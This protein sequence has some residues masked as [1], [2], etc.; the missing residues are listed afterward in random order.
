MDMAAY[1]EC[2]RNFAEQKYNQCVQ[3]ALAIL[4][5]D[6]D[7]ELLQI[8]L[9]SLQRLGKL[10]L[11]ERIGRDGLRVSI[12]KPWERS[13]LQL[14]L[15]QVSWP[16]VVFQAA[17]SRQR[18][19]AYY[20]AGER[21]LT[22]GAREPAIQAFLACQTTGADC[23]E[24]ELAQSALRL[25][26]AH[27]T[28][29][30]EDEFEVERVR[31]MHEGISGEVKVLTPKGSLPFFTP[32]SEAHLGKWLNTSASAQ[33]GWVVHEEPEQRL[34]PNFEVIPEEPTLP[35][36]QYE[37]LRVFISSTFRDMHSEREILVKKVFPQ[38]RQFCAERWLDLIEVDLRWGIPEE[39]RDV[40]PICLAELENS[41]Y[42][43]AL[44][45]NRY[46][47]VP[48]ISKDT[49]GKHPWLADYKNRSVTELEIVYRL[50][51]S[52][53]TVRRSFFYFRD[54]QADSRK[55]LTK[56]PEGTDLGI[57]RQENLKERIMESGCPVYKNYTSPDSIG[58]QILNDL[59]EAIGR[60][61]PIN[62]IQDSVLAERIEHEAV[63]TAH[64]RGFVPRQGYTE[65]LNQ[66]LRTS[67]KPIVVVGNAG[68]GKSALLANWTR[69][70][71]KDNPDD[72]V[73]EHY[74]G[75]TTKSA[76][77]AEIVRRWIAELRHRYRFDPRLARYYEVS[78]EVVELGKLL[79][80]FHNHLFLAMRLPQQRLIFV[81]DG[82]D[83]LEDSTDES[84]WWLPEEFSSNIKLLL[85]ARPGPSVACARDR[86]W[87]VEGL[88]EFTL[89]ELSEAAPV[90]LRQYGKEL[91]KQHIERLVAASQ[92]RQPL[93]LRVVLNEL[94]LFG[95]HEELDKCL[96][97]HL[98]ASDLLALYRSVFRRW[99]SDYNQPLYPNLVE[100]AL[101]LLAF[102][103]N[104]LT[105]YEW[106]E[107]LRGRRDALPRIVWAPLFLTLQAHLI[108]KSG[109]WC[110][111]QE[112]LNH[113][114]TRTFVPTEED[115][116][117]VH[118]RLADYFARS[119]PVDRKLSEMPW[120]LQMC[121]D[122][123][124]LKQCLSDLDLTERFWLEGRVD[125]LLSYWNALGSASSMV[126]AY[127]EALKQDEAIGIKPERLAAN[128][129]QLAD[130]F[131]FVGQLE[132]AES[133]YRKALRIGYAD[134]GPDHPSIAGV[135]DRLGQ[136]LVRLGKP[137]QAE[138]LLRKVLHAKEMA[139]GP[140]HISLSATLLALGEA[141]EAQRRWTEAERCY[142][143]ALELCHFLHG[144]LHSNTALCAVKL[145][146]ILFHRGQTDRAE[147]FCK[148][149]II[150]NKQLPHADNP[151]AWRAM[152]VL[153]EIHLRK[154]RYA[155]A[156]AL[157]QGILDRR[158]EIIGLED[159]S[160]AMTLSRLGLV[161]ALQGDLANGTKL[162][163][164]ALDICHRT[165]GSD[166]PVTLEIASVITAL[167]TRSPVD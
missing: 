17:D 85:S 52:P 127:H 30:P 98:E 6:V 73:V 58:Q 122:W 130:I 80:A 9:I 84:L 27:G 153:A 161:K 104:G 45:G 101:S 151:T 97:R 125:E 156:E 77:W 167:P 114:V 149:A 16:D 8:V 81:L 23:L 1:Q 166:H 83:K 126:A 159:T 2:V 69:E 140:I 118:R 145:G 137:V 99:Q 123:V 111:A 128:Y 24:S 105:E 25:L 26:S 112:V 50:H 94:R 119:D 53:D 22:V 120:H 164:E 109:L 71:R 116:Y 154:E 66:L 134:L 11:V 51:C 144:E 54:P 33:D 68:S 124:Q 155:K 92:A 56:E 61:Y 141:F 62:R 21:N 110:F 113:A 121:Q 132:D 115:Q 12:D 76:A 108:N 65:R 147:E 28:Q 18:C 39:R 32:Y 64:L 7:L 129:I 35:R 46:G 79:N 63:A 158:R 100:D 95:S 162:C 20:Y 41:Q 103:R 107:L 3:R 34:S 117:R 131:I 40:L 67:E 96:A 14:T 133:F 36:A 142:E 43:V 139:L 49:L 15:G 31:I 55:Q 136:L 72:I 48:D 78:D 152:D 88:E 75:A 19:Q 160:V 29:F 60:D 38:L 138:E 146:V 70:H 90:Y 13:L 47:S 165:V 148:R 74:I 37:T 89:E 106:L 5:S 157:Y 87:V 135:Q 150:I 143:R 59:T 82:L 4:D 86:G 42:F 57:L 44:L 93:Y 10:E 91:S 163:Q 102:S